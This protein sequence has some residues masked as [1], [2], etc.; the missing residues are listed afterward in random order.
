MK[1]K[2]E[3]HHLC[4]AIKESST[5]SKILFG[6]CILCVFIVFLPVFN[7]RIPYSILDDEGTEAFNR[8][9][10]TLAASYIVSYLTYFFTTSYKRYTERKN[11]MWDVYDFFIKLEKSLTPLNLREDSIDSSCFDDDSFRDNYFKSKKKLLS[12]YKTSFPLLK[13]ILTNKESRLLNDLKKHLIDEI[14]TKEDSEK[15]KQ[16]FVDNIKAIYNTIISLNN[17]SINDVKSTDSATET[18]E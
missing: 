15:N 5:L 2:N 17:G 7:L 8:V 1:L 14:P 13:E 10:E 9:V 4:R 6:V 12:S 18:C 16:L 11:R 3:Y